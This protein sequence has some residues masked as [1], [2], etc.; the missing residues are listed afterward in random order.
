MAVVGCALLLCRPSLAESAESKTEAAPAKRRGTA[1]FKFYTCA[2]H[3]QIRLEK[4]G[5]CPICGMDLIVQG[6]ISNGE[7][8]AM[9][10]FKAYT[11]SMHPQIRL[12]KPGK[13]PICG[14]ELVPAIVIPK[15]RL[16]D[17]CEAYVTAA[18]GRLE[19][20]LS[21]PPW[22]IIPSYVTFAGER[23]APR[24]RKLL[25][26][27]HLPVIADTADQL[28]KL[29]DREAI[30]KLKQLL[31][32]KRLQTPPVYICYRHPAKKMAGPGRCPRCGS[33]LRAEP[34]WLNAR[35]S[36]AGALYRM[37]DPKG[38][39]V[40]LQMAEKPY[41]SWVFPLLA[42]RDTKE[43]RAV[44]TKA[45][46][47]KDEHVRASG[48]AALVQLGDKKHVPEL[49]KMLKSNSAGA[50]LTALAAL[51]E[52]RDPKAADALNKVFVDPKRTMIER[53]VAAKGLIA[54]GK[55]GPLKFILDLCSKS[56]MGHARVEPIRVLGEVGTK[57]HL[58]VLRKIIERDFGHRPVAVAAALKIFEREKGK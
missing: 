56:A 31:A 47:D 32:S 29:G 43:A 36:I 16:R 19:K 6:P 53:V 24:L 51:I 46:T 21:D 7:P 13:C 23:A 37:K 26:N 45:S 58:P 30:P 14:M 38:L 2:M 22:L 34:E 52:A 55:K 50:R 10:E 20:E 11:C 18:M 54:L 3:P 44:F 49:I 12:E 8:F 40:L 25:G 27:K 41:G 33:E 1:K 4:P 35:V 57:E 39:K 15:G 28:G 9:D 48:L 42:Q 5:K 17:F